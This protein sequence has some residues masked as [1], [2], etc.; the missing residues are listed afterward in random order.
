MRIYKI[1]VLIVC[2]S[3]FSCNK[4]NKKPENDI[5]KTMLNQQKCWNN[6][7]IDGF[8]QAYWQNDSLKFIGSKGINYGWVTT[9]ENYKKSYPDKA[10]MGKLTFRFDQVKVF[11]ASDAYVLGR[12]NLER[13]E[14]ENIGGFFSLIWKKI[15]GKWVIVSDHTS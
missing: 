13:D 9:L 1:V 7:D 2:V 8:M 6:G 10:T 3:L 14:K 11:T 5:V 15:E 4:T 12:W